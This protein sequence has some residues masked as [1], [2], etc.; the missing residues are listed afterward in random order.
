M[1]ENK[2]VTERLTKDKKE[3]VK[4]NQESDQAAARAYMESLR[5]AAAECFSTPGGQKILKWMYQKYASQISVAQGC[6][7]NHLLFNEARRGVYLDIRALAPI[8]VLKEI[9]YDGRK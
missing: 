6:D 7:L 5:V 2:S 4:A 8:A 9:E 1:A 3:E